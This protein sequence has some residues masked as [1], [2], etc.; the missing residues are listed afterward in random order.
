LLLEVFEVDVL[1][2][3]RQLAFYVRIGRPETNNTTR[4]NRTEQ[5]TEDYQQ[6]YAMAR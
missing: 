1:E 2:I 6:Y 3:L 4:I 5:E